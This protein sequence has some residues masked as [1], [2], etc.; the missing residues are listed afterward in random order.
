MKYILPLFLCLFISGCCNNEVLPT[1]P[2][3][4][5]DKNLRHSEIIIWHDC[6]IVYDDN[7]NATPDKFD[8]TFAA[9]KILAEKYLK[10]LK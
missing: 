1:D 7:V 9:R 6:S 2:V 5:P 10:T 3:Y 4:W 8:S